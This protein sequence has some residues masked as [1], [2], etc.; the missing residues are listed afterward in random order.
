MLNAVVET[1]ISIPVRSDM[2][3]MSI[4]ALLGVFRMNP[5]TVA[6]NSS[7]KKFTP[8]ITLYIIA[9]ELVMSCRPH[10]QGGL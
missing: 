2:A 9:D 4:G 10:I 5:A 7:K 6:E 8:A 3:N 1:P